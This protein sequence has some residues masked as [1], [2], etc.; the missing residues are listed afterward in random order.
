MTKDGKTKDKL[1]FRPEI[2]NMTMGEM[3]KLR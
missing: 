2:L 3:I 1:D